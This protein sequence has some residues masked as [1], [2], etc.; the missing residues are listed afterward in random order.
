MLN[1]EFERN[2]KSLRIV[3][4]GPLI[5]NQIELELRAA[6]EGLGVIHGF[7]AWIAP[8]L[9]NGTLQ[10]LLRDWWQDFPGP[11]LYYPSRRHM[12]APLRAFVDYI[13]KKG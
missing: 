8:S 13:K 12:P 7:E 1:W 2:G 9:K 4:S 11:L 5:T 10:P 3:P 6:I